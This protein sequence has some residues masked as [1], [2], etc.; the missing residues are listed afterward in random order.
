MS[1]L[2]NISKCSF[3]LQ[4]M[5]RMQGSSM[6]LISKYPRHFLIFSFL[7]LKFSQYSCELSNL[8]QISDAMITSKI[9]SLYLLSEISLLGSLTSKN[10]RQVLRCL[11]TREGCGIFYLVLFEKF[12][13]PFYPG[14]KTFRASLI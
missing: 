6:C 5:V 4:A 9:I 11:L 13:I 3:G 10:L 7:A 8:L 14:N 1:L 12:P 2:T